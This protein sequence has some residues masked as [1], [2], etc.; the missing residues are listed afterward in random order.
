M[1]V[2]S[3]DERRRA[4]KRLRWLV[5]VGMPP[6]AGYTYDAVMGYMPLVGQD[7]AYHESSYRE[8]CLRLADL[9]DP[10]VTDYATGRIDV[11]MLLSMADSLERSLGWCEPDGDG[12][13]RVK[14]DRLREVSR[15]IREACGEEGRRW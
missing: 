15:R 12:C 9:I 5:A 13:V 4:A 2:V 10:G 8:Y 1:H 14:A 6:W 3:Y 7:S 11:K